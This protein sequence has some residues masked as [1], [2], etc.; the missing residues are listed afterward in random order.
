MARVLITGASGF[1]GSHLT[2][3]CL[4][5]GDEVAI[6][7]RPGSS[8][9]RLGTAVSDVA[10]YR[11][12]YSDE[13]A[14]HDCF[15][16]FAPDTVFHTAARTRFSNAPDL[17]DLD[18]SI[19]ENLKSLTRLIKAAATCASPPRAFVRTGT[20]AEYGD[21]PLPFVETERE[22]PINTYG[23][24][25]LA[26]TKYLEMAAPR[27]PFVAVTA[28]LALTYGPG[29]SEDFLIP[30][31]I[32]N[33]LSDRPVHLRRPHDRRD[34]I[35]VDD[36]V[37][38]LTEIADAP[39]KAGPVINLCT[40]HAPEMSE[41]VQHLRSL[42]GASESMLKCDA[43]VDEPNVLLPDASQMKARYGWQPAISLLDGLTRT[44]QWAKQ[45]KASSATAG[46]RA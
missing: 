4:D 12:A 40:G 19:D 43:P 7:T 31:V 18:H 29:Q 10:T 20:I 34:L 22:H 37:Q 42:A 30:Q 24:S 3:A 32:E 14:L 25:L 44:F 27:L 23:T 45:F 46:A 36:V 38:G 9:G 6:L 35:H 2:R 33:L 21:V 15:Q 41:V 11:C 13:H 39:E 28:R 17:S 16:D 1:I 8:L 26:G 5:R